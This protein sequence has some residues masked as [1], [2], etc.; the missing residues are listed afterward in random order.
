MRGRQ[1]QKDNFR[2]TRFL[3]GPAGQVSECW[4][5]KGFTTPLGNLAKC[6]HS[7]LFSAE[8]SSAHE[9]RRKNKNPALAQV[10]PP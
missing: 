8:V 4:S 1:C 3:E 9:W 2:E 5:F 7:P 10:S 6:K